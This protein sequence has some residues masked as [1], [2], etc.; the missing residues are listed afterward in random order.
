MPTPAKDRKLIILCD[1]KSLE[2]AKHSTKLKTSGNSRVRLA[3]S[4]LLEYPLATVNYLPGEHPLIGV[5]YA[6]SRLPVLE[7]EKIDSRI[8]DPSNIT[9]EN[10]QL[11]TTEIF[12]QQMP[13]V[14]VK[15][16]IEHQKRSDKFSKI[17][18][19]LFGQVSITLENINYLIHNDVLYRSTK[20]EKLLAIVPKPLTKDLISFYHVATAHSGKA[21]IEEKI[22]EEPL[23]PENKTESIKQGIDGCIFCCLVQHSRFCKAESTLTIIPTNTVINSRELI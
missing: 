14:D 10:P 18:K 3:F 11:N 1:H 13:V 23:W 8:F 7:I 4:R 16:I 12:R 9:K 15:V 19:N 22:K 2:G 21:P 5:A 6:L 17:R 20:R